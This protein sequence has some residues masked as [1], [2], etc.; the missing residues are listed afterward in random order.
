M[1]RHFSF[2]IAVGMIFST[3][4]TSC[5][6]DED[7]IE[8][9]PGTIEMTTEVTGDVTFSMYGTGLAT[10]DW[11][12]GSTKETGTFTV[13]VPIEFSH[14]YSTSKI[15]T[16]RIY[17]N[18]IWGLNCSNI[19]LI[20]LDVSKNAN[21]WSLFCFD[22]QLTSLDVSKNPKLRNLGCGK[23][24][25]TTLDLSNN[26][27]LGHL[28]CHDNP[29]ISLDLSKNTSL[30]YFTTWRN[31]L[32]SL[33]VSKN[34]SLVHLVCVQN[35]LTNLDVSKNISLSYLDCWDNQLTSLDMSNNTTLVYLNCYSNQFTDDALDALF[36]SLH[37]NPNIIGETEKYISIQDNP[38]TTTCNTNIA[39]EK[40]WRVIN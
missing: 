25:L 19:P 6:R 30:Y 31:Q 40:G 35:Q 4:I 12:D 2:F 37:S 5:N 8:P 28:Q 24:Q 13:D 38:G 29:L 23:N 18:D 9:N 22:N 3:A 16:I 20:S 34:T 33:D 15:R 1:K 36:G 14:T 11:G 10:V 7:T 32:T 21:L 17:G 27:I 39:T 26:I